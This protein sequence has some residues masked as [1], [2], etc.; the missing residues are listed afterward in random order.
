M[1]HY[2]VMVK[3]VLEYL[4]VRGTGTYLDTTTGLGGHTAE[5]ARRLTTG[6]VIASDRDAESLEMA[7]KNLEPWKDKVLYHTGPFSELETGLERLGVGRV[8]GLLADLGVSYYQLTDPG[9]GFSLM[10]ESP[11]DMRMDRA[12]T[13]T[14]ADLI[15]HLA[16]R[17]LAQL[18]YEFGEEGRHSR[19][20]ARAIVRARPLRTT[21]QLAGVIEAA[22]PRTGRLHPA[23]RTF[24]A[25]R[26]VV[27][28]E[29]EELDVL[30]ESLPRLVAAGGRAVFLTFHSL[31]D[32]KVKFAF[33]SLAR[34]GRATVLTKHV[35]RPSGAE[36]RENPP[37]RS[38]KLRAL[39]MK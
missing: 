39:E 33:R 26:L 19:K 2:P 1:S 22:V 37:S 32:R 8:D 38:A 34:E 12:Q 15:N 23:T 16:E 30:L 31:E 7:R 9:R 36:T 20:I 18:I 10:R 11:L 4:A 17:D 14:A 6:R 35:I 27:N 3:E 5:I 28:R 21:R 24:M 13:T 25:L 29:L